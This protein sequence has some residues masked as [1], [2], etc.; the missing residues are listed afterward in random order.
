MVPDKELAVDK[1]P[2]NFRFIAEAPILFPDA[3]FVD[4]TRHPA[5]TFISA[6]QTEMNAAHSYSYDPVDYAAYHRDI[7]PPDGALG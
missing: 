6:L 2:I 7:P 5:D 1:M 3:R 4:C